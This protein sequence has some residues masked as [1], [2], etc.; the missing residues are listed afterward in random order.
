MEVGIF[1][2]CVD[3]NALASMKMEFARTFT[4]SVEF[5]GVFFVFALASE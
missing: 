1:E 5:C 4:E 3:V 2:D